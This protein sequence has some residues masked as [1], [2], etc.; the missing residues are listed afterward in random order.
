MGSFLDR[1]DKAVEKV[2]G[3]KVNTKEDMTK[4]RVSRII[5]DMMDESCRSLDPIGTLP[6]HVFAE[7]MYMIQKAATE[8]VLDE[9]FKVRNP[10]GPGG[11]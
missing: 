10:F 2:F 11:E 3:A 4:E 5:A 1:V 6:T 9:K 8:E 7:L